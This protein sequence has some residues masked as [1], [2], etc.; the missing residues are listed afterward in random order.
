MMHIKDKGDGT[1]MLSDIISDYITPDILLDDIIVRA[2]ENIEGVVKIEGL[3][4]YTKEHG[5]L[6]PERLSNGMKALICFV[7][8]DKHKELVSSACMGGNCGPFL[9]ELSFKYDFE[10]AWDYFVDM[11]WEEPVCAVDIDTGTTFDTVK[12]LLMFY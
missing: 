11:G 4:L 5:V 7:M 8:Y 12:D 10:I 9:R 2:L 6:S 1:T 3:A